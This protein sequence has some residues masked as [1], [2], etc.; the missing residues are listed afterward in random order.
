MYACLTTCVYV[1]EIK[2]C[3]YE[4]T[5]FLDDVLDVSEALGNI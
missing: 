2:L 3:V 5:G 1:I 4:N